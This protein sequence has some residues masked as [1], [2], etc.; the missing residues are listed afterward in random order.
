MSSIASSIDVSASRR[1][2]ISGGVPAVD[3]LVAFADAGVD[4]DR[5]VGMTYDPG[6]NGK[7]L[8]GGVLGVPIRHGRHPG[9]CQTL[10]GG[11]RRQRHGATVDQT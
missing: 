1:G 7:Q 3:G 5:I 11:Q 6:M 8:K 9:Q 4:E 10:D 2:V